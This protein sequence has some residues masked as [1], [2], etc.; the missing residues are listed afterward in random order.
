MADPIVHI[1][2][3]IPDLGT[4]NITTLGQTLLD[5]ANVTL[6][7]TTDVAVAAG[8]AGTINAHLRSISRDIAG[9][10]VL[11]ASGVTIGN[12]GQA[13]APWTQNITQFGSSAVVTGTG[14][15]GAG[16]P[17]VTVSSDS[18][19]A[20]S[21]SGT[22]DIRNISGTVPL[23]SGAS[24]SAKQP[25]LGTA[26]VPSADVLTIQGVGGMTALKVDGTGG[27][28]PVSGTVAATQSGVWNI[29]NVSGT[30]NLPTGAATAAK[31]PSIGTAGA[32]SAD[33][34]TIQ[35]SAGM[36]AVKINLLGSTGAVLDFAGQNAASPANAVLTGG[37]FNTTP[38][39]LTTGNVSPLQLDSA[40]NLLVNIKA[41]A[42]SGGT[43]SNFGSAFPSSGTAVGVKD[44]AGTNM[45]FLQVNASNALKVDGSAVT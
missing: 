17:R 37:Q 45:T 43:A 18:S 39:T 14:I 28:F 30:V 33:V 25:A 41:G 1:T 44:S 40:G 6:G 38:T 7:A 2:N 27:S 4:G 22:W 5:G 19:M 23:P 13:G 12:V 32:P 3:G 21:Q 15:G 11:Q 29:T 35:G 26:G 8:A 9:G 24:T 16:V 36:T 31:Q 42:G 20:V 34:I 10:I